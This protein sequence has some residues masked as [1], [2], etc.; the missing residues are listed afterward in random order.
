MSNPSFVQSNS[1]QGTTTNSLAFGANVTAGNLIIAIIAG[2]IDNGVTPSPSMF[3][4]SQGNTWTTVYFDSTYGD[5]IGYAVAGSTGADTVYFYPG[6][7]NTPLGVDCSLFSIIE[8]TNWS[9]VDTQ[10]ALGWLAGA[11]ANPFTWTDTAAQNNELAI[12]YMAYYSYPGAGSPTV[13]PDA[14]W[15]ALY[16]SGQGAVVWAVVPSGT[17]TFSLGQTGGLGYYHHGD[18]LIK[19]PSAAPSGVTNSLMMVG[20]GI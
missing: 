8:V 18:I 9:T 1:T 5:W 20:L 10:Q 2:Q 19:G 16:N 4:D 15:N 12:G 13:I 6:G 3:V 7:D 17:V 11:S 14:P